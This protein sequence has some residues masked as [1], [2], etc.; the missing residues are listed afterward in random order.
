MNYLEQAHKQFF[1]KVL[2]SLYL[3]ANFSIPI[4]EGIHFLL[5]LN[6][7]SQLHSF[8]AHSNLHS[9]KTL[10]ILDDLLVLNHAPE[11]PHTSESDIKFKKNKQ[12]L[13]NH[14]AI[15]LDFISATAKN[16]QPIL[17]YYKSPVLSTNSPPPDVQTC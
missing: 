13:E 1:F 8:Q 15:T 9:H 17:T 16:F 6:D 2:L 10:E 11:T 14:S 7:S 4:I 12:F 3:I 5:H